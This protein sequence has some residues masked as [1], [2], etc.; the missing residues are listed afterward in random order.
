MAASRG[1]YKE[2]SAIIGLA[3][4]GECGITSYTEELCNPLI[5]GF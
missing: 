4:V 1:K 5:D 3:F 2:S